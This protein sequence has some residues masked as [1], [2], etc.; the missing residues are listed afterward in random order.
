M[1][2]FIQQAW[3]FLLAGILCNISLFTKA[4]DK[5][6]GWDYNKPS[7]HSC[8]E[9]ASY[10]ITEEK[11]S[12]NNTPLKQTNSSPKQDPEINEIG[13]SIK[14]PDNISEKEIDPTI[15]QIVVCPQGSVL[16]LEANTLVNSAGELATDPV[17]IRVKE[18]YKLKDIVANKLTTTSNGKLIETAGMVEI[19][20]LSG[21]DT[22]RLADNRDVD[23]AMPAGAGNDYELFNAVVDENGNFDW[24]LD[25]NNPIRKK[26]IEA[27]RASNPKQEMRGMPDESKL[28]TLFEEDTTCNFGITHLILEESVGKYEMQPFNF[29]DHEGK[30]LTEFIQNNFTPDKK[31]LS[32]ACTSNARFSVSLKVDAKGKLKFPEIDKSIASNSRKTLREILKNLPILNRNFF[33]PVSDG[34]E[35]LKIIF[36]DLAKKNEKPELLTDFEEFNSPW[37]SIRNNTVI[38]STNKTM[39]SYYVMSSMRLGWINC[40]RYRSY[41]RLTRVDLDIQDT[42][43][44]EMIVVFENTQSALPVYKSGHR[45]FYTDRLIPVNANLKVICMKN[46]D[47]NPKIFTYRIRSGINRIYKIRENQSDQERDP[48]EEINTPA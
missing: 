33:D 32:N 44:D 22:L 1:K 39:L 48:G 19:T 6:T 35:R 28:A 29:I 12:E 18:C 11:P 30:R 8:F 13:Q 4:E 25:E 38:N 45:T 2:K 42:D 27:R 20:A 10:A 15:D 43:I 24:I 34:R 23:I 41:A 3:L 47:V 26:Y 9:M 16:H 7:E 40:D 14:K 5:T 37:M 36:G 21:E 46:D 31:T 17:V